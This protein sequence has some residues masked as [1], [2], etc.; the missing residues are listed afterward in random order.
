[1]GSTGRDA[2]RPPGRQGWFRRRTPGVPAGGRRGAR[3]GGSSSGSRRRSA[4]HDRAAARSQDRATPS[5]S[6]NP[7]YRFA[8]R[9][10]YRAIEEARG[11]AARRDERGRRS[12]GAEVRQLIRVARSSRHYR[13]SSIA[14]RSRVPATRPSRAV[15]KEVGSSSRQ[16]ASPGL[17][18]AGR[19]ALSS[20]GCAAASRFASTPRESGRKRE[21]FVNTLPRSPRR[22]GVAGRPLRRV[23]SRRSA[24]AP[25]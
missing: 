15:P 6:E 5:L 21:I 17:R 18:D 19:S 8:E 25:E 7:F 22:S 10:V 2:R 13:P 14:G 3:A 23:A 20:T 1:M 16:F 11:L 9:L 4:C 12:W 24:F